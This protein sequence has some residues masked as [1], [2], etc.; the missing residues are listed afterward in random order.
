[1]A[2]DFA[3]EA[4]VEEDGNDCDIIIVG[5]GLTG[6][7]C[8][9]NILKKQIGLDVLI[10]E[11]NS[12]VGGRILSR[13]LSDTYHANFLQKRV[14]NLLE[15]LRINI[16]QRRSKSNENV[17]YTKGKPLQTLP[18]FYAAEVHSFL[19]TIEEN[20]TNSKFNTYTGHEDARQIAETSVEHLLRKIVYLPYARSLCRAFICSTCTI[21]NLNDVSALW[22]LVILNGA[23]GLYNRLKVMIGDS[24]RYFVQGGMIKIVQELLKNILRLRGEIR[25]ADPVYKVTVN[26]ERV[27]V[28]T[29]KK[30]FRYYV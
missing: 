8:A 20:A 10:L 18:R 3:D 14:T 6:L 15:T 4:F 11:A 1:M 27:H 12:E 26:D 21:R 22:F 16:E 2:A 25:Y 5:A 28:F 9:Y 29:Q 19:Q 13:N 23:S 24:N 7:T 30:H 17:L